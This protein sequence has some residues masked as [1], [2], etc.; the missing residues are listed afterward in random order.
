[1]V[2]KA[3]QAAWAKEQ[4]RAEKARVKARGHL[5]EKGLDWDDAARKKAG[6]SSSKSQDNTLEQV[7]Q[8]KAEILLAGES[9]KAAAATA[10]ASSSAPTSAGPERVRVALAEGWEVVDMHGG[11]TGEKL[12]RHVSSGCAMCAAP[13]PTLGQDASQLSGVK[14]PLG[15]KT[16]RDAVSGEF[17]FWHPKS[18]AV[19]SDFVDLEEKAQEEAQAEVQAEAQLDAQAQVE[20]DAE[21]RRILAEAASS[22]SQASAAPKKV[23]FSIKKR[24]KR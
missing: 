2:S 24:K 9:S 22:F 18:G 4:R 13:R 10:A 5:E 14:V 7:R 16:L 20:A 19:R 12:F 21:A 1:M 15:W 23:G 11:A 3:Q 17:Y 8:R 6:T